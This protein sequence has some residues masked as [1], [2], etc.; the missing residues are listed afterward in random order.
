ML[1]W[2]KCDKEKI[3]IKLKKNRRIVAIFLLLVMALSL[4]P[5]DIV[6]AAETDK[7]LYV[8]FAENGITLNS[9]GL[10]INGDV[11]TNG[12]FVAN[13]EHKN[14]DIEAKNDASGMISIHDM[15]ISKYFT[16][17]CEKYTGDC[18]YEEMNANINNSIYSAGMMV[19]YGNVALN[20]A[21][22]AEDSIVVSDGN[23]N[24][25][26]A[27]MYSKSGDIIVTGSQ[28]SMTGL[29]YAPYGTVR[30]T[31]DNVNITG[32]IIAETVVIDSQGWININYGHSVAETISGEFIADDGKESEEDE[33]DKD[34]NDNEDIINWE[35][36]VDTDNDGLPDVYEK[37]IGTKVDDTDTDGDTL[38]DG[39]E[40][41]Y[42]FTNPLVPNDINTDFDNDGLSDYQESIYNT[43]AIIAD[44][45]GDGLLDGEEI[46]YGTNPLEA[47][48]D[49][50]GI[51]DYNEV[52]LGTDPNSS[53][54]DADGVHDSEETVEQIIS[55]EPVSGDS[56]VKKVTVSFSSAASDKGEIVSLKDNDVLS[57][58]VAGLLGEPVYIELPESC[59]NA[60]LLF[61]I[62]KENLADNAEFE[63][64]IFLKYNEER[65]RYIE[66]DVIYDISKK[67][68]KTEITESGRYMAIDKK[69]WDEVWAQE[70]N[71]KS[72]IS[73]FAALQE[74]RYYSVLVIDSSVSMLKKDQMTFGGINPYYGQF[75]EAD[76]GRIRAGLRFIRNMEDN[77]KA[78]VVL[79]GHNTW[80]A[81]HMTNEAYP[82]ELALQSIGNSGKTDYNAALTLALAEFSEED[83]KATLTDFNII[84]MSDDGDE[85]VSDELIEEARQKG[86]K[87]FVVGLGEGEFAELKKAVDAT[88][89]EFYHALTADDLPGMYEIFKYRDETF[90]TIDTDGDGLYDWVEERGF[91]TQSGTIIRTDRYADDTDGDGLSDGEEID[92]TIRWRE[93]TEDEDIIEYE[94]Y[95]E[96]YFRVITDPN[97]VDTD[98]DGLHDWTELSYKTDP[99]IPDTDRDGLADGFEVVE[100]YNPLIANGDGDLYNDYWEHENGTNPYYYDDSWEDEL[101]DFAVG[102]AM[103][104][105]VRDVS[106]VGMLM[107]Q[108]ASG[109]L[110]GVD[111]RDVLANIL[112]GDFG[113]AG[114]NALGLFEGAGDVLKIAPK[115]SRY[116]IKNL[117][118]VDNI[119]KATRVIKIFRHWPDVAT[120]LSKSDEFLEAAKY[121]LKAD[122]FDIPSKQ[123]EELV[124]VLKLAGL[125]GYLDDVT[126]PS[127]KKVL[128]NVLEVKEKF[129]KYIDDIV[130]SFGNV[131]IAKMN[132]LKL[133]IQKGA[134]TKEEISE[135]C[136]IMSE[137]GITDIYEAT[138]KKIKF[139]TYLKNVLG[140]PPEDMIEP[141]AHHILFKTGN[142]PTQQEFVKE[143]QEI[144]RKYGIDP[145]VGLENLVWAP[146]GITGQHD[147]T[148]LTEVVDALRE[149]DEFGGDYKDIVK[150][151]EQFGNIASD[152]Q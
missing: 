65:C 12:A 98:A 112:H 122:N 102:F 116:I 14:T 79:F 33:T 138:M 9:N 152:R 124:D 145:V 28:F 114:L 106:S 51:N 69:V 53:D 59:D 58:G 22:G 88:G 81:A 149:I 109:F 87:I 41:L 76:C 24:A 43:Y 107:G 95:V 27:V 71:Y 96:V 127:I 119:Y 7:Y 56:E 48:T 47:D 108:V 38:S 5:T 74:R 131:D 132:E 125:S 136:K 35:D 151:L 148:A 128:D 86:I 110:P 50:D 49:R 62:E 130:D 90:D 83:L 68:I 46:R 97:N 126:N 52:K 66:L 60:E 147:I 100:G 31:A 63:D 30:I 25:N 129:K 1:K 91:R 150:V 64:I 13:A 8:I 80:T 143:G 77:D 101:A 118:N 134:F 21:L 18:L 40:C 78:A 2:G 146:N 89:G 140:N 3:M 111:A 85:P 92:P 42:A 23:I 105:F 36:S 4:L 19:F 17:E 137:L 120:E 45:D 44:S 55:F 99:T 72:P 67:T 133:A 70:F 142:G 121:I 37:S 57:M 123:A 6:Y 16:N 54:G 32:I 94:T 75:L 115:I 39:Y 135:L 15:L 73:F 10:T 29:I 93:Y 11:A 61:E 141:H 20:G 117:D 84:I 26:N 103:G 113:Y 139:G 104:D 34:S 82:L 144:L